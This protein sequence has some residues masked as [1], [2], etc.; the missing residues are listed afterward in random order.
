[1]EREFL[2]DDLTPVARDLL[3]TTQATRVKIYVRMED[4]E[5]SIELTRES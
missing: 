1:M 5:T 4:C 3:N 2:I